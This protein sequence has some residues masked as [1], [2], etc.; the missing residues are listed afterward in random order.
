MV[1]VDLTGCDSF[2]KKEQFEEYVKKA[3]EAQKVL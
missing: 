3:L 1:K 2:V